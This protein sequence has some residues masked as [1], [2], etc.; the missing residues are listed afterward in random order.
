MITVKHK[1]SFRKAEKFLKEMDR[2]EYMTTL[3]RYGQMG[4]DALENA[5]PKDT[6]VT[7]GSWSYE[8]EHKQ[9][10]YT[11]YW[12]NSSTNEGE[13]IALLLQYGHGTRQGTYVQG[14]D[15]INPALKQVFDSMANALW[16]E[17]QSA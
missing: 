8:I 16:R 1:G 10:R 12:Q 7:A 17:V 11:I 15:Y 3:H 5:T 6:G 4:L 14:I 9:G 2:K 13:N